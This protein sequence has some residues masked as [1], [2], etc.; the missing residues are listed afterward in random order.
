METAYRIAKIH[1][2]ETRRAGGRSASPAAP[3]QAGI[4]TAFSGLDARF[5]ERPVPARIVGTANS[6]ARLFQTGCRSRIGRRAH[7]RPS[8]PVGNPLAHAR[9]GT[10]ASKFHGGEIYGK[11]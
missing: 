1:F 8:E 10:V 11:A 6:A 2:E 7:P 3:A 5:D 4:P 9:A